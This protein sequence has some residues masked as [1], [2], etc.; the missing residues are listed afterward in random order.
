MIYDTT[1]L[2]I[3]SGV[4]I[5]TVDGHN[6]TALDY[7]AWEYGESTKT[8]R[9]LPESKFA[10]SVCFEMCEKRI[11]KNLN[12]VEFREEVYLTM[13]LLLAYGA[14]TQVEVH[15]G[16]VDHSI[17]H[18]LLQSTG[19]P[20]NKALRKVP[21]NIYKI[22]QLFFKHGANPNVEARNSNES[23]FTMLIMHSLHEV[24]QENLKLDFV[25][26]FLQNGVNPDKMLAEPRQY[27]YWT[28]K[29]DYFNPLVVA[30]YEKHPISVIELLYNFSS[31]DGVQKSLAMLQSQPW[32]LH[33]YRGNSEAETRMEFLLK[34]HV[35]SLRHF[36]KHVI[37]KSL[38]KSLLVEKTPLPKALKEYILAMEC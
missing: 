30:V 11:R 12:D 18:T 25:H 35:W 6:N 33:H 27:S 5:N 32:I 10:T 13:E 24:P 4:D 20:L 3:Q 7:L 37:I 36:C 19:W 21:Q 1:K 2:L 38:G 31:L 16:I 34:P 22:L 8:V 28:N 23:A 17:L 29:W 14:E 26:L 15:S 9:P